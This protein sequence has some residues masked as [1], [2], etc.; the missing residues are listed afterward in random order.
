MLDGEHADAF[1]QPI[2]V[3]VTAIPSRVWRPGTLPFTLLHWLPADAGC[4]LCQLLK[5]V[6]RNGSDV[7]RL[8]QRPQT[9][10]V[11]HQS[12][13]YS[14]TA[15]ETRSAPTAARGDSSPTFSPTAHPAATGTLSP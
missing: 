10:G 3:L 13:G 15:H 12:L 9:P 4:A 6:D 1:S 2:A 11:A 8:P 5:T 14:R 7:H